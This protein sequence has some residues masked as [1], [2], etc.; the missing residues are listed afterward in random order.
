MPTEEDIPLGH[1]CYKHDPSRPINVTAH[2]PMMRIGIIS[3][4][5]FET[6]EV[7]GQ[8][9]A[10]CNLLNIESE[11]YSLDN[12][13]WDQVKECG[14]NVYKECTTHTILTTKDGMKWCPDCGKTNIDEKE[15]KV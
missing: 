1:Y 6:K 9:G 5:Y 3:C 2:G 14:I 7:N 4:P 13:I 12:L 11:K 10:K 8:P 15:N